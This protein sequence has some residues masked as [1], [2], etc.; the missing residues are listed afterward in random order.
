MGAGEQT[1]TNVKHI[2]RYTALLTSILALTGCG[3]YLWPR[4][5][6]T[7]YVSPKWGFHIYCNADTLTANTNDIELLTSTIDAYMADVMPALHAAKILNDSLFTPGNDY[8]SRLTIN[9]S[10]QISARGVYTINDNIILRPESKMLSV[11][12]HELVRHLLNMSGERGAALNSSLDWSGDV[13][14]LW[15]IAET[16]SLKFL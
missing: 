7:I 12:G 3:E 16:E 6:N 5:D 1:M 9:I 10:T 2:I 4:D 8:V 13:G 11:F 15:N 14:V